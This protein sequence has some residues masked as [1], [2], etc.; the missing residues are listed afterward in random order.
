MLLNSLLLVLFV[1]NIIINNIQMIGAVFFLELLLN[2]YR[3]KNVW[4]SIKK[5]KFLL[6]IYIGMFVMQIFSNQEGEIL[7]K[8]YSVYITKPA[9]MNFAI[10]FLRIINMIMLSWLVSKESS[11]FNQFGR[12][13]MVIESVIQLV[14]EV[15]IVF[16]KRMKLKSFVRYIFKKINI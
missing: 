1:I 16:R 13:K 10:N 8:V 9:I 7:F 3:N 2:L 14:P 11:I 4:A 5:L 15:F 12:Y 6:Y